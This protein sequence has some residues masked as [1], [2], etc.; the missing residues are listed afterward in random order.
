MPI[1][2]DLEPRSLQSSSFGFERNLSEIVIEALND[3]LGDS[4]AQYTVQPSVEPGQLMQ[5]LHELIDETAPNVFIS[6]YKFEQRQRYGTH[7]LH[8]LLG[9]MAISETDVS[10]MIPCEPFMA[11]VHK[12]IDTYQDDIEALKRLHDL[13][14]PRTFEYLSALNAALSGEDARKGDKALEIV[15]K[16]SEDA[17]NLTLNPDHPEALLLLTHIPGHVRQLTRRLL[18]GNHIV[19]RMERALGEDTTPEEEILLETLRRYYAL[20]NLHGQQWEAK[21]LNLS[22]DSQVEIARYSAEQLAIIAQLQQEADDVSGQRFKEVW[23]RETNDLNDITESANRNSN[24]GQWQLVDVG[25]AFQGF[26]TFDLQEAFRY[27]L[28]EWERVDLRPQKSGLKAAILED[29]DAQRALWR[30]TV[31]NSTSFTTQDNLT[32]AS[33]Q[34]LDDIIDDPTIGL[35]V[36]DIQNADD[37][38]AGIRVGEEVIRRRRYLEMGTDDSSGKPRKTKVIIWS[39]SLEAVELADAHFRHLIEASMPDVSYT[40]GGNMRDGASDVAIDIRRKTWHTYKD[41]E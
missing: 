25:H 21:D 9:R 33:P 1:P 31:Q 3:K 12:Q 30:E 19:A 11:D 22:E 18:V 28:Y 27:G 36:L 39:A 29:D 41:I 32:F 4:I 37:P 14:P 2:M 38:T 34:G 10:E 7:R 17:E 15:R 24:M 20:D 8:E 16:M 35:F 40:I 26:L 6:R 13:W 5:G 23:V